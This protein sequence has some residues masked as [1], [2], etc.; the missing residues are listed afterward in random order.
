MVAGAASSPSLPSVSPMIPVP[1]RPLLFL[2][3]D[4]TLAPLVG[5]P[6]AAVPHPAVPD[7]LARLG[8]LHPVVVIT[9]RDLAA[10]GRLLGLRLPAVGLHGAEEG[11]A[12]GT[13][14]TRADD[15]HAGALARLRDAVPQARGVVVE[16]KGAAF[17]V[18]YRH[19]P[20]ADAAR[21]ALETWAQAVPAGLVPI[22]GKSVVE[23]RAEGV[24]KGTAVA[25]LAAAHPDRT[26]V[27]LG[28]DVTDEDA[29]GALQALRTPS[30]TVKVGPGETVAGHRL[31]DVEAVVAYL[32]RFLD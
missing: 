25:R 13:V 1:S 12:D 15:A 27:Y 18:H 23:L 24:S 6:S 16:D 20:D 26:P 22:W 19:A 11:W 14:E 8:D 31:P 30:V 3:Y 32:R 21:A 2:D 10:L 29:F 9:G 4:G 7:L 17:A 28:D 5:D